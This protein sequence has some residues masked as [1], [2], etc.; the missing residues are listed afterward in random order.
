MG[1]VGE[2]GLVES[3]GVWW[4]VVECGGGWWGGGGR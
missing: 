3:D 4:G 2:R 1:V